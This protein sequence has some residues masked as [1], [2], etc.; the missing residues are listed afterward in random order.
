MII[1]GIYGAYAEGD[2]NHPSA[3]RV[4]NEDGNM[5]ANFQHDGGCTIFIN[6]EH[7]ISVNEERLSREKYDGNFPKNAIRYCLEGAEVSAEDVDLVYYVTTYPAATVIVYTQEQIEK[8][9][10]PE[11]PNAE[12]RLCGH[13][14]A[15]AASTVFTSPY[16]EG[17]FLTVDG[18]GSG[19]Y[20]P[21]REE[22]PNVEN[23]SIGYFNKE[24]KVFRFYNMPSHRLNNFGNLYS[25]V[26]SNL[27]AW[28]REKK[29]DS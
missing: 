17:T 16:N 12:V 27:L 1:V 5:T 23:N 26:A 6:G 25:H 9:I 21:Y 8:Y 15:H 24:K 19:I 7:K 20:D 22:I 4:T 28:T 10:R 3:A 29:I 13:H 11:F 18:G 14:L 2:I